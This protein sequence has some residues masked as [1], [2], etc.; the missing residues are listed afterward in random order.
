MHGVRRLSV[1][2]CV[3][4]CGISI[5]PLLYP[6]CFLF[7]KVAYIKCICKCP[8]ET[9]SGLRVVLLCLLGQTLACS[10]PL[11]LPVCLAHLFIS[12]PF[13]IQ[14]KGSKKSGRATTFL[15]TNRDPYHSF[16]LLPLQL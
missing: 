11:F 10:S 13:V 1:C 7:V 14:K 9:K 12:F 6:C 5:Q 15:V 4:V 16:P 2:T 8:L 3:C